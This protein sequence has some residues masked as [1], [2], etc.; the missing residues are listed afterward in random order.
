[1]PI[2]LPKIVSAELVG[3]KPLFSESIKIEISDNIFLIAGG[4][5][6][7]KTTILQ[8][9]VY[10]IAGENDL[11]V[12][13]EKL[14][15][16]SSSYFQGR[17]EDSAVAKV[18]IVFEISGFLVSVTRGFKSNS[19][20]ELTFNRGPDNSRDSSLD[21]EYESFIINEAGYPSLSDFR[22]IVHKL[23][24][25]PES[26]P[27]LVW[28]IDYQIR[29]LMILFSDIID[30]NK[31]RD[32]R[33]TLKEIDSKKRHVNVALNKASEQ[34]TSLTEFDESTEEDDEVTDELEDESQDNQ[35]DEVIQQLSVL[36]KEKSVL[37]KDTKR[38]NRSLSEL[39]LEVEELEK[40]MS[41]AQESFFLNKLSGLESTEAR[42]AIHKLLYKKNC[43]ACGK[44]V[45][46]LSQ[47]ALEYMHSHCCPICGTDEQIKEH[48]DLP[49][50]DAELSEKVRA[51]SAM[52]KE[53]LTLESKF[54]IVMKKESELQWKMDKFRL[55]SPI[56]SSA[57][58]PP[59]KID[60]DLKSQFNRLKRQHRQ[61]E[62]RFE[63]LKLELDE[64]YDDFKK[65]STSRTEEL[66]KLYR[67]YATAF[68][69]TSCELLPADA[70]DKF[71]NLNLFVPKFGGKTR[72]DPESCS[73]AQRFFMD[74]AFRMALIDL[75]KNISGSSG[76]FFCETPENSLDISY[77]ENVAEMFRLFMENGH[78]ILAT[79]NIQPGG[80]AKPILRKKA[81]RVRKRCVLNLFDFGVLSDVQ[82]SKLGMINDE[83]NEIFK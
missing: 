17:I 76:S 51:R 62:M 28:N 30:E 25:L 46:S 41:D 2:F 39:S 36:Y 67:K 8:A 72:T 43:P 10:C 53:M 9:V 60:S 35:I 73:E 27:S 33:N 50:L 52:E 83:F 19:I 1:M 15:R 5:G 49:Q 63:E 11:S 16:W 57:Y 13:S 20:L 37:Q 32:K 18:K 7:G 44:N 6:L 74:I 14:K 64:E 70:S 47:K 23:L 24:Y 21:D 22:F 45:P 77:I 68:L 61:L 54:E 66:N 55:R 81:I 4:N 82:K 79:T 59:L 80:L 42:L 38:V 56:I 69:G 31:F 12:E 75:A 29:I 58:V 40:E 34:L 26:R 48:S 78:A 3:F 65:S 71:L